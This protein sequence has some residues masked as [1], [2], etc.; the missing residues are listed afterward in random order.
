VF[1]LA[2]SVLAHLAGLILPRRTELIPIPVRR[3]DRR[4]RRRP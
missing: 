2:T 1:D 4:G 3:D